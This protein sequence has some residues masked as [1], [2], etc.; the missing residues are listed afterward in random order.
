MVEIAPRTLCGAV[1]GEDGL[2]RFASATLEK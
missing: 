1:P 2:I